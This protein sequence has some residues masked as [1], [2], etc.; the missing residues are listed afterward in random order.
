MRLL[1]QF[2]MILVIC[3]SVIAAGCDGSIQSTKDISPSGNKPPVFLKAFSDFEF[4]GSGPISDDVE[5]PPHDLSGKVFP[6]HLETNL[7]YVFHHHR[8]N[9]SEGK[10]YDELQ[11]RLKINGVTII[12]SKA[13]P[14]RFIGGGEFHIAFQEGDIK[15]TI[16]TSL[17]W[18]I[19]NN[20][21]LSEQWDPD[22]YVLVLKAVGTPNSW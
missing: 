18:Q 10:L 21:K 12:E 17:D 19:M 1:V 3:I 4:V 5:V 14:Y 2:L 9:D 13:G 7:R 11:N 22:D 16:F 8:L 20:P 6:T 15:G